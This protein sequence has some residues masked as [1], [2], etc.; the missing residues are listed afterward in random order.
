MPFLT[1]NDLPTTDFICRRLVI[2]N[3]PDII[4]AVNGAIDELTYPH[5]WEQFGTNTPEETAEAMNEMW[6]KY[7]ED[8]PCMT[9]QLILSAG[10]YQ[11]SG[12]LLCDGSSH[13]RVD[14][15]ALYAAID[16]SYH[17]DADNFLTPAPPSYTGLNWYIVT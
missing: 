11:P 16:T 13:L 4:A 7:R 1:G 6:F 2:P 15:P 12:T 10:L 14:Y 5:N 17:V 9:A 8:F 3:D